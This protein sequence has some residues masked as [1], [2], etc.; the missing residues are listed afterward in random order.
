MR[1]P[2]VTAYRP[3]TLYLKAIF[4][5]LRK[6]GRSRVD[7]CKQIGVNYRTMNDYLNPKCP[8]QID[9]CTQFALDVLLD[10]EQAI[11]QMKEKE[12]GNENLRTQAQATQDNHE[13]AGGLG[14]Q[15]ASARA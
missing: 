4:A 9:Y 10:W 14:Q 3:S 5:E 13:D 2:T 6:L 7:V 12:S 1:V 11:H 8:T 15:R